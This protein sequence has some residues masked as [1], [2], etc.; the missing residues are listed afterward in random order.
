[1]FDGFDDIY[2]KAALLD[3]FDKKTLLAASQGMNWFFCVLSMFA[4]FLLPRQFHTAIVE[5]NSEKHIRTALW[6]FPLYLLLLIFSSSQ[7][8]GQTSF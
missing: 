5:N 7:L 3:N 1:V 6:L 8:L 4:I 2:V